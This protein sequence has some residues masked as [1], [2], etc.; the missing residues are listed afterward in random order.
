M[1]CGHC[2]KQRR[3]VDKD[4]AEAEKIKHQPETKLQDATNDYSLTTLLGM[5]ADEAAAHRKH[6]K[7]VLSKMTDDAKAFYVITLARIINGEDFSIQGHTSEY[8][9]NLLHKLLV[10][11]EMSFV[12]NKLPGLK[13]QVEKRYE[14]LDKSRL[15]IHIV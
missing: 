9:I 6:L 3:Y 5:K 14:E 7:E 1:P 10:F 13:E 2:G 15:K 12:D 8:C 11:E 4:M